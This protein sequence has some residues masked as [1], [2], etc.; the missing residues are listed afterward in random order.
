MQIRVQ[1]KQVQLIRSPYD[2]AKKRCVQKVILTFPKRHNG[3]EVDPAKYLS[4]DELAKLSDDEVKTLSDWLQKES[5]TKLADD[6]KLSIKTSKYSIGRL[7]DAISANGIDAEKASELWISI[8]LL[9]KS[10]RKAGYPK[11]TKKR[12]TPKNDAQQELT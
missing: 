3:Y 7:A 1:G 6:R 11:P 5:D 10:M 12:E 2:P 8:D 4:A 9:T